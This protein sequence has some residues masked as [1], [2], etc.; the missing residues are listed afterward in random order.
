MVRTAERFE[1]A[2]AI[3]SDPRWDRVLAR[4]KAADGS[5]WYSVSTT[6]VFC[7]PSCASRAAKPENVE[8]HASVAEA[9]AA[10]F[11]P[12]LRCN[13]TGL[14]AKAANAALVA[15]VCR[16]ID[17]C[18]DEPSLSDMAAAVELSQAHF[19]RVFKAATG[20][21][22]KS[23]AGA[24]RAARVREALGG[25]G[26]VTEAIYEAGFGSS[27]RFYAK[28]TE[29]LGMTPRRFQ[30]GGADEALRFAVGN[31]SLGAILVASSAKGVAAILFGDDPEELVRSFQDRFA[32]AHLVGGDAEYERLVALV[33]GFVEAPRIGLDL[34]LDIRGT[35]FQQRV[36]EALREIPPGTTSSYTAVAASVG[37]PGAVRAVAG[38]CAANR[39]AVAIP[40]HRVVRTDGALSGYRWG[41]ERKR[42]LLEMEKA[43]EAERTSIRAGA[44]T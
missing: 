25:S 6:G 13:P 40:C 15:K 31:C 23:Y 33:V 32:R 27:G 37:A 3:G 24:R 9:E 42:L 34:P 19:H 35:V 20:V 30:A 2:S 44:M 22:P 10:G 21:T 43:A 8:F 18:Q 5:F 29:M 12:C 14:S 39:L 11:R 16:L 17:E 4:D 26:S 1:R 36:W 28:S 7:R 38:A 41:V